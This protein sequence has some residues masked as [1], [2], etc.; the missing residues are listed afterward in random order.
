MPKSM[1]SCGEANYQENA[2]NTTT[3]ELLL[4]Y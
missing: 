4:P 3:P 1:N 2:G